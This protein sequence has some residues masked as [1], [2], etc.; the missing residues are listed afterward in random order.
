MADQAGTR[1]RRL[2]ARDGHDGGREPD[3]PCRVAGRLA[4]CRLPLSWPLR[5]YDPARRLLD[6]LESS[7]ASVV[8]SRAAS[9]RA[10]GLDES[11]FVCEYDYLCAVAEVELVEDPGDVA[12]DCCLAED[13]F[14][15]DFGV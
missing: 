1:L 14:G 3:P 10:A 13:E 6:E 4:A 11:G 5:F 8:R 2:L 15:R 7:D 12:F 9:V